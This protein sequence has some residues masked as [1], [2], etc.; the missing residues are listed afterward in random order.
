MEEVVTVAS[1]EVVEAEEAVALTDLNNSPVRKVVPK[2]KN[3]EAEEA[4]EALEEEEEKAS[5]EA[6]AEAKA[7]DVVMAP[8][9]DPKLLEMTPNRMKVT[10]V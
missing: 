4:T 2:V 9:T 3:P 8:G 10:R 7:E 6:R 5:E 1:E